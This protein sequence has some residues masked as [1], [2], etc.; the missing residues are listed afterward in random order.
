MP[1]PTLSTAGDKLSTGSLA[2]HKAAQLL[3]E[4]VTKLLESDQYKAA[5][6]F[7]TKF[8]RYSFNNC[9]LIYVQCPTATYIAGYKTWQQLGR[10]VNKGEKAISILA[11]IIKKVE[12][13][14]EE[15]KRLVGFRTASVFDIGQTSGTEVP[16]IPKPQLLE[17][18]SEQIQEVLTRLETFAEAK[19]FPVS[20]ENLQGNALG[21]FSL[22]SYT[23]SIRTDLEPLQRTKTLVHEL[24]HALM[25]KDTSPESDKGHLCELE[26]E[27]CAFIVCNRLG[28]D[29]S[30]YSFPYLL[31][32]ADHPNE[33]LPAAERAAKVADEILET[34]RG[35]LFFCGRMFI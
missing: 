11:P 16:E 9:W 3:A 21:R 4:S 17:G 25:H 14:G 22:L 35:L 33:L 32:W 31:N 18:D 29:T 12:E 24:A 19:G 28:L 15:V 2:T 20:Y 5:L 8:Y 10:Q 23:I 27:S 7:K 13:N 34:L 1:S 6:Q 26:A 30:R